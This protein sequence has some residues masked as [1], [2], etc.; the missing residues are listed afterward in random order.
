MSAFI[1]TSYS[2]SPFVISFKILLGLYLIIPLCL[3]IAWLDYWLGNQWLLIHLPSSPGHFLLFQLLFG[4]PHILASSLLL[5]TNH[6]YLQFYQKRLMLMSLFIILLFGIG[7]LWISYRSL[8]I[9]AACWTVHHVLK[10]QI[11]VGR[12]VY[13]LPNYLFYLILSLSISC[14]ILIYLGIFLKNELKAEIVSIIQIIS[15]LLAV[16]LVIITIFAQQYATHIV[17]QY[18]LYANT[19]LIISS[20]YLYSQRYYFLAILMP[21]LVHDITAYLFYIT[22]DYN[23]HY[24]HPQNWFYQQI[25]FYRLPIIWTL[26]L[27]SVLLTIFLQ[28]YGND[29]IAWIAKTLLGF[30]IHKAVSLGLIGYLSLMH[31]Y[32]EGFIWKQGSPLR[33]FIRFKIE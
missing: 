17:G 2:N 21:R 32:T 10:Q 16:L 15:C 19:L 24:L 22:H 12:A 6:S 1:S 5:I 7:S 29:L 3:I 26:P 28:Q 9:I 30:E 8:Y 13:R 25:Q 4:T 11:G 33:Q 23:K 20:L 18:F 27:F 14:G 31:Y